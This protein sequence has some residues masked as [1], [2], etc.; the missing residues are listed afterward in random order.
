M[1]PKTFCIRQGPSVNQTDV[2][3]IHK[4]FRFRLDLKVYIDL[5]SLKPETS[6]SRMEDN[7]KIQYFSCTPS[8]RCKRK[9]K[10]KNYSY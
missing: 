8:S 2:P 3:T 7:E 5:K 10:K 1:T 6:T 4:C 9:D